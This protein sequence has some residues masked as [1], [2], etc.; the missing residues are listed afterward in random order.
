[1]PT[2]FGD[3]ASAEILT[4]ASL[5]TARAIVI[6]LPDDATAL[7]V[8]AEARHLAPAL[9][10]ISRAS[11]WAGARRLREAGIED[12][13]RPE[14]EGGV[15]LARRTLADLDLPAEDVQRYAEAI[16]REEQ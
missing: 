16:R 13:V 2:L 14:L 4:H 5:D 3:A 1:V 11:T 8:A 15:E 12:V 9:R 6:T 7:A 10:V